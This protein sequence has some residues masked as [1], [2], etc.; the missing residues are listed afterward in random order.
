MTGLP[1]GYNTALTKL[2]DI[3]CQMADILACHS[4]TLKGILMIAALLLLCMLVH[5]N[6]YHVP[7]DTELSLSL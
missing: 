1:L 4:R 3:K 6:Y 5:T 2:M 7:N